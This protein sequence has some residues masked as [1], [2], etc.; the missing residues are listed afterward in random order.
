M[1]IFR[2][3]L[4]TGAQGG[5]EA[6]ANSVTYN[7]VSASAQRTVYVMG[8]QKMNRLL[9]DGD[10]FTDCNYWKRFVSTVNG[11]TADD[12]TAFL[13]IV[14]DDGNVWSDEEEEAVTVK[15]VTVSSGASAAYATIRDFLTSDL[16]Y[17]KFAIVSNAATA[18]VK[19]EIN[20]NTD[21]TSLIDLAASGTIT[22]ASGDLLIGKIRAASAGSA[23][24]ITIVYGIAA[25]S[26]S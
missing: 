11:G 15:T 3:E 16:G 18:A 14:S 1:S 8:P 2:V 21:A 19:L 24:A 10:T 4:S 22:F 12:N 25:K 26:N 7:G 5:L 9:K 6:T 13:T 23:S 17:A 20:G